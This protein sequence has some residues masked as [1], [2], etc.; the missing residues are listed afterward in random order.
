[1]P[2]IIVK[3]LS[4]ESA[5]VDMPTGI[6]LMEGLRNAGYDDVVALCG[7]ALSCATC[8]VH[9]DAS[10]ATKLPPKSQ[11]ER[12]LLEFSEARC[13]NSRLSC[14]IP[15]TEDLDKLPVTLVSVE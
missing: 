1:M 10:F 13:S 6:T 15:I 9:I 7:G 3:D 4:G 11:D 5:E 12:D 14:Q 8:H 2:K